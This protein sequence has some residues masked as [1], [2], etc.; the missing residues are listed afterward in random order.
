MFGAPRCAD[1]SSSTEGTIRSIRSND[2][3]V[4]Q[5]STRRCCILKAFSTRPRIHTIV[6]ANWKPGDRLIKTDHVEMDFFQHHNTATTPEARAVKLQP[7]DCP[8]GVRPGRHWGRFGGGGQAVR[9][10]DYTSSGREPHNWG[11]T[12]VLDTAT[13]D[14]H[15]YITCSTA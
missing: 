7:I 3:A 15:K 10:T 13:P 8:N 14:K 12:P 9:S 2:D 11:S 6:P 5:T 1:S 4:G